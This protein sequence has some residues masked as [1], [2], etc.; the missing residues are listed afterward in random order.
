MTRGTKLLTAAA[1]TG[2]LAVALTACSAGNTVPSPTGD[3]TP[4]FAF[5]TG[6]ISD[7]GQIQI[8]G[9]ESIVEPLGGKIAVFD[10]GNDPTSQNADCMDVVAS[11][12]YN[13]IILNPASGP[14]AVPCVDAAREAGI[15]VA[16]IETVIGPDENKLEPQVDGVV[17]TAGASI[18]TGAEALA[19]LLED[20]C[21]DRD[22]C[23]YIHIVGSQANQIETVK[24]AV[25]DDRFAD[26]PIQR[27]ALGEDDYNAEKGRRVASELLSAHPDVDVIVNSSDSSAIQVLDLLDELGRKDVA[28]TGD[29]GSRQGISAVRDGRLFGTVRLVPFS[30]GEV[31]A[32]ALVDHNNGDPVA[33]PEEVAEKLSIIPVTEKNAATLDGQWG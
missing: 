33:T 30:F 18:A 19:T 23:R 21:A 20:A 7:F 27:V 9:M 1:A 4:S 16:A 5:I 22:P 10:G 12:K 28:V 26:S 29:G 13:G 25:F 32:Q 3:K 17:V 31:A 8:E 11:G 2:C 24:L 6:D 14:G 15:P